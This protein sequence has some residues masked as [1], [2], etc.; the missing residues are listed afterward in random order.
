MRI[1]LTSIIAIATVALAGC[2]EALTAR[3]ALQT[4]EELSLE[5]QAITVSNGTIELTTSFTIGQAVEAA[6]EELEEFIASQLPC[7]EITLEGATLSIVYGALPGECTYHGQT[8]SGSHTIEIVS[9]DEGE[10]VVHHAWTELSNG[11]LEVTG[12]A[13]VTWSTAEGTR[14]VI[15]ELH[16]TRLADGFAVTGSGDRT[17]AAL[18]GDIFVGMTVEGGREWTS[19][20]GDWELDIEGVELRWEDPVP[21]AGEYEITTPFESKRGEKKTASVSFERKDEDT[22]RVTVESGKKSFEFDVS[23]T[24]E[25]AEE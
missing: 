13:D 20:R 18:D 10:V 8:Y 11:K 21:Q 14:H 1:T 15:H 17:Q 2:E 12:T 16:W 3:E 6:A 7:A 24:G 22:I 23:K 5:S 19:E 9:A 4:V 25:I